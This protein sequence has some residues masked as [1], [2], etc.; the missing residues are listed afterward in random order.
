MKKTSENTDQKREFE[1]KVVCEMI[2]L[3][4]RRHPEFDR[5]EELKRYAV[6]KIEK[7]PMMETKTFCSACS[8][9]CY[10]A[11]QRQMIREVMKYSGPRMLFHHPLMALRHVWIQNTELLKRIFWMMIGLVGL[12][13]G[14]LGAILPLLPAFPFLLISACGFAKSSRRMHDW[15]VSTSLYKNNVQEWVEQRGMR[16]STKKR[17]LITVSSVLLAGFIMMRNT[18]WVKYILVLVWLAHIIYFSCRMKTLP[19]SA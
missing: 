15:F 4:D 12:G 1:K 11:E 16:R 14:V 18:G 17:V 19:E 3:Y 8:I 7:C 9:H 13:L 6:S 10:Q 5:G 2:D